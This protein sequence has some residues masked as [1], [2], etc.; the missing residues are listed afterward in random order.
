MLLFAFL[1]A[2]VAYIAISFLTERRASTRHYIV[3]QS[4]RI[5]SDLVHRTNS[6]LLT[7]TD[8]SLTERL[9]SF[10][11]SPAEVEKVVL[12]DEPGT[13]GEA[14]AR[15]FLTNNGGDRLGI[16]LKQDGPD[17]FRVLN[18]WTPQRTKP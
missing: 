3:I 1:A 12:G 11:S 17:K 5:G 8:T 10:L 15:L 7:I 13:T 6:S 4:W 2:F 14:S 9:T 16:R 18:C